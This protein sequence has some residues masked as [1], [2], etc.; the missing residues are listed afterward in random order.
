MVRPYYHI[1]G[2][3]WPFPLVACYGHITTLLAPCDLSHV[4]G[5]VRPVLPHYCHCVTIPTTVAWLGQYDHITG[6]VWHF[7]HLSGMIRP[8]WLVTLLAPCDLSNISGMVRPIWP[9][10]W[11]RD[12]SHHVNGM[13]QPILVLL[14]HY[15]HCV[16]FPTLVA[17]HGQYY[18]ITGTVWPFPH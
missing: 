6:T 7:P 3:V 13:V 11:H 5:M 9:H 10:N 8:V 15:W 12:L 16:A 18:H 14:P 4:S 17:W 2:S 1:T